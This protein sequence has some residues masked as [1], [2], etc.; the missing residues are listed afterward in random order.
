MTETKGGKPSIG[1]VTYTANR[2]AMTLNPMV[3]K[4]DVKYPLMPV[5]RPHVFGL[6]SRYGFCTLSVTSR[7][8]ARP[9]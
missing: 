8:V 3:K 9:I 5:M 7:N 4:A 1:Q 6:N 2:R